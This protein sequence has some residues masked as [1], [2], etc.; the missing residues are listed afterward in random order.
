MVNQG[1]LVLVVFL[2]ITKERWCTFFK[3]MW[4]LKTNEAKILAILEALC[5]YCRSFQVSL[6]IE[7]DSF[8]V[9]SWAKAFKGLWKMEFYFNEIRALS[10]SIQ[11]SFIRVGRTTN[12]FVDSLAK[13]GVDRSSNFVPFTM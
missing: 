12:S 11:V 7:S 3:K 6:I 8:N 4:R 5:I 10:Y 2:E 13:E 9:V 1:R